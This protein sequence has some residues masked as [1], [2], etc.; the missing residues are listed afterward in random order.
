MH[1]TTESTSKRRK[2]ESHGISTWYQGP[3]PLRGQPSI[4]LCVHQVFPSGRMCDPPAPEAFYADS[5]GLAGRGCPRRSRTARTR[6]ASVRP[7]SCSCVRFPLGVILP[8]RPP[9]PAARLPGLGRFQLNAPR[10][11]HRD[12]KPHSVSPGRPE[13]RPRP[14]RPHSPP[15]APARLRR[16]RLGPATSSPPRGPAR[17]A[18]AGPGAHPGQGE[19][20]HEL[21][22]GPRLLGLP[23]RVQGDLLTELPRVGAARTGRGGHGARPALAG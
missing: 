4:R 23:L 11:V 10:P 9:G 1:R 12:S 2:R 3:L 15:A 19:V 5:Q 21:L 16:R 13:P 17:T 6:R 7:L 14:P 20:G 18:R 8:L 22:E